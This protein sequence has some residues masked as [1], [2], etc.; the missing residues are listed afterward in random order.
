M[1][2]LLS[3]LCKEPYISSFR[4][5]SLYHIV[6]QAGDFSSEGG[7]S[8]R[9]QLDLYHVGNHQFC[10]PPFPAFTLSTGYNYR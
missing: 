10:V 9:L 2:W 5:E 6:E 4:C 8:M 3:S 1:A 7:L